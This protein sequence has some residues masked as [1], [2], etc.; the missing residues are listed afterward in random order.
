MKGTD[1]EQHFKVSI[2]KSVVRI[3]A[4]ASL[5][6]QYFVIAGALL[7]FAELLGIVEEIV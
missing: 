1:M 3:V 6:G 2:A 7:I 5:M 4:G